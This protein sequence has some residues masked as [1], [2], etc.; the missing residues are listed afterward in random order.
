[1]NFYLK[2]SIENINEMSKNEFSGH[3]TEK[4]MEYMHKIL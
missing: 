1:M 2:N 3:Y 4:H